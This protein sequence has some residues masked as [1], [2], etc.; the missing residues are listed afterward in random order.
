MALVTGGSGGRGKN[1]ALSLA[2]FSTPG[3]A[4]C[5]ATKGAGEGLCRYQAKEPG[6]RGSAV[7]TVAP[8]ALETDF[9]GGPVRDNPAVNACRAGA[10]ALGRAG[11]PD[12]VGGVVAFSCGA[13]AGWINGQRLA[14]SGGIYP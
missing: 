10:T 14:A 6:A 8:G 7:N 9:G 11:P 12:D 5:A 3:Y 2:R 1:M 4:A 13:G